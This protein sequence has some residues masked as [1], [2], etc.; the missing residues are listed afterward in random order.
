MWRMVGTQQT[1]GCI[2]F[3]S[4]VFSQPLLVLSADARITKVKV[5]N[6]QCNGED[7]YG[8]VQS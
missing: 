2:D 1:R 3:C 8:T 5:K 7:T 6:P 4:D